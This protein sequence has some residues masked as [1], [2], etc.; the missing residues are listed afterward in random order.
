MGSAARVCDHTIR[1][2]HASR[3]THLVSTACP[4]KSN[5]RTVRTHIRGACWN[6]GDRSQF[7]HREPFLTRF[8]RGVF[9]RATP[10]EIDAWR[11]QPPAVAASMTPGAPS[12]G[13]SGSHK[14][15]SPSTSAT[16]RAASTVSDGRGEWHT[17]ANVQALLVTALASDGWRIVSVAYT[18]SK[19]HGVDVIASRDGQ[20]V[21]VEVKGFPSR[22]YA[23]PSRAGELKR[24]APSTQA[25]HW[26]SQAVLAAMR[27]RG[28]EPSWRSVITLPDFPRYRHLYA[29]TVSSLAAASIEVWWVD[30]AGTV[31]QS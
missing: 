2:I 29:E 19:E 18:A 5:D 17:E 15:P 14:A 31:R 21:G 20:I 28:K 16:S 7:S 12:F 13:M 27:L 26:Y 24:T 3:G 1:G 23:D 30:P 22:G 9:R 11:Q 6:V 25:A 10:A 4:F 8:D